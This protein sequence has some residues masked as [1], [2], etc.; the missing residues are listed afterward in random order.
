[1][2]KCKEEKKAFVEEELQW[3]IQKIN[4][5]VYEL[6]YKESHEGE[7]VKIVFKDGYQ[8][9][10]NVSG[11]SLQALTEDVLARL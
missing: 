7:T 5:D 1:M 3:M 4:K 2:S 8:R 9:N 10:I 11:D 6:V